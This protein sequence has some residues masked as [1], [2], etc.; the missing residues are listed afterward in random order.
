MFLDHS[1]GFM[2]QRRLDREDLD[3]GIKNDLSLWLK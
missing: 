1:R 3:E 2:C